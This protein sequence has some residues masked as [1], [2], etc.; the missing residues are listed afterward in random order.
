MGAALAVLAAGPCWFVPAW[1]LLPLPLS[2]VPFPDASMRYV[3]HCGAAAP[4]RR[5]A[6][7]L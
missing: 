2:T 4:A 6:V 7:C 3:L 5:P 1:C